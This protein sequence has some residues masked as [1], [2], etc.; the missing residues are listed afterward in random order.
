MFTTQLFKPQGEDFLQPR[1]C[2]YS[3]LR[4]QLVSIVVHTQNQGRLV[5]GSCPSAST[6]SGGVCSPGNLRTHARTGYMPAAP[7]SLLCTLSNVR[8][9]R[10][11]VC[12]GVKIFSTLLRLNFAALCRHRTR[13][14]NASC[15]SP[16]IPRRTQSRRQ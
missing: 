14:I 3:G 5:D 6:A 1:R 12:V 7:S 8:T 2:F 10:V 11:S 15:L 16:S 4:Y 13:A 9:R